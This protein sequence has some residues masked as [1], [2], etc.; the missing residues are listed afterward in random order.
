MQV[1]KDYPQEV[2]E[3]EGIRDVGEYDVHDG[4]VE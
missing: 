3:V 1:G 4:N 2:S